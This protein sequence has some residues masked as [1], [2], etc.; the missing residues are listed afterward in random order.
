MAAGG[1]PCLTPSR[2]RQSTYD[3]VPARRAQHALKLALARWGVHAGLPFDPPYDDPADLEA[4]TGPA[5]AYVV[6]AL[7]WVRALDD[8]YLGQQEGVTARPDYAKAR[9]Q[10]VVDLLQGAR[11]AVNKSLHVLVAPASMPSVQLRAV[12]TLGPT[13]KEPVIPPAIYVWPDLSGLPNDDEKNPKLRE[14]YAARY[15]HHP[16]GATIDEL[17]AWFIHIWKP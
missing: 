5:Q 8:Y 16:V 17:A 1:N 2:V 11:F 3:P 10:Q 15:V 12:G 7:T 4:F 6:E 9:A 14:A 13:P